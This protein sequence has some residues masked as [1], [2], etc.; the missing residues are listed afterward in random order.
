MSYLRWVV[1]GAT[2][3]ARGL[4]RDVF[5]QKVVL[6]TGQQSRHGCFRQARTGELRRGRANRRC[7]RFDVITDFRVAHGQRLTG[8]LHEA[9]YVPDLHGAGMWGLEALNCCSEPLG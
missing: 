5:S 3:G 2:F 6:Q 7:L 9:W 1:G 8:A 4:L